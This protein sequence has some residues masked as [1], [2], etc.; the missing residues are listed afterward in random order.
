MSS[1][2]VQPAGNFYDKYNT[3]NPVARA[4]MQ[5]FLRSFAD[6]ARLASPVG[7]ALEIGCGEGELSIRLAAAGWRVQGCDI[8]Q[9]AVEEARRRAQVAGVSIPFRVLNVLDAKGEFE[10]SDLVVCCEVMEHL[11]D[12]AAALDI[13]IEL[14]SD[15]VLVSVPREPVWRVLN[16]ARGRYWKEF[17]NTP[18]HI[19]HWSRA[20]FLELLERRLEI[21]AVRSP[22]P[23]TLALC[24]VKDR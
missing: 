12:P 16:M 18:G 14:S 8:A 13:L 20:S 19:Q 2:V 10:T 24:R 15:Y 1:K 17:G 23:W 7:T 4:M 6:L 11:E 9:E 5:G 22:L 21:I 3:R